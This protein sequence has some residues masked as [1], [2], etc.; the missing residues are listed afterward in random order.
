MT[1]GDTSANI[2]CII[3]KI[4]CKQWLCGTITTDFLINSGTLLRC[5]HQLWNSIVSYRHIMEIPYKI[6]THFNQCIIE[7]LWCNW[8]IIS[9]GI[10]ARDSIN[11]FLSSEKFHGFTYFLIY[12]SSTSSISCLFKSF[13]RNGWYKIT[14]TEHFIRKF[15]VN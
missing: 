7:F 10:A 2:F 13:Q 15:F 12:T 3:L 1:T 11:Q 9:A 8:I 5:R 14:Y 6:G 4:Q